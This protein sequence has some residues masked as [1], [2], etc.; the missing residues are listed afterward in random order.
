MAVAPAAPAETVYK[1]LILGNSYSQGMQPYLQGFS[2]ADP[3]VA[4]HI[5]AYTPGGYFLEDHAGDATAQGYLTGSTWDFVILQEQSQV[6]AYAAIDY[7]WWTTFFTNGVTPL[8]T[9]AKARGVRVVYFQTWARAAGDTTTLPVFNDSPR[10]MQNALTYSYSKAAH[11]FA[12]KVAP[13]GEAWWQSLTASPAL[14]LHSS[15][16][17]HGNARGYYLAAATIYEVLTGRDSRAVAYTGG[18]SSSDAATLRANL[19]ALA[20]QPNL[21]VDPAVTA[22]QAFACRTTAAA[23]LALGTVRATVYT[24]P[25]LPTSVQDRSP[26]IVSYALISGNTAGYF[27]L[28]AASGALTVAKSPAAGTYTLGVKVVDSNNWQAQG[29]VTV[30]VTVPPTYALSGRV[31]RTDTGAGVG[32]VTVAFSNGGGSAVT[33]AT[34]AYSKAIYEGWSGTATPALAGAVFNPASRTYT[35]VTAAQSA[36]T[37]SNVRQAYPSGAPWPPGTIEC[38]NFDLGGA[39]V[40]YG[41]TAAT[42]EG[43]QYRTTEGVDIAADAGAGNG[44]TVGWT[45]PGEWLEYTVNVTATG[46]YTIETRVAALGAGGQFRIEVDGADKTGT[47]SVPNTGAWNA[48]AVVSKTGVSLAAGTHMVRLAMLANGAGGAVGAFDWIKITREQ[49]SAVSI[50]RLPGNQVRMAWAVMPGRTYRVEWSDSLL[51]G[52][53]HALAGSEAIVSGA[54]QDALTLVVTPPSDA[55]TRVYRLVLLP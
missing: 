1:V 14:T 53:W 51:G 50:E 8:T 54:G 19:H 7:G 39:T 48:Y 52:S 16:L 45:A 13:V 11:Y 55:R 27:A 4:L 22:G 38:E 34:G 21:A 40:A 17:S 25:A 41:D 5:T 2:D 35:N 32:G 31:T 42:N 29:T 18:L 36:Q 30:T 12:A 6:G 15:D 9:T 26:R 20:A 28:D 24:P 37:Y 49:C 47:L 23:G 44:M 10:E 3:E 43:G 46:T 33:D